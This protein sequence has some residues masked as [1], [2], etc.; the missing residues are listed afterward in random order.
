MSFSGMPIHHDA[1]V[2]TAA[3]DDPAVKYD[4]T[5][6]KA[7]ETTRFDLLK[8]SVT[9]NFKETPTTEAIEPGHANDLASRIN[10]SLDRLS[11]NINYVEED[12]LG[13]LD[14]SD[15]KKHSL[16]ELKNDLKTFLQSK[17]TAKHPKTE[18]KS[19]D[20][21]SLL[22]E[23]SLRFDQNHYPDSVQRTLTFVVSQENSSAGRKKL[24]IVGYYFFMI[25]SKIAPFS[26][27]RSLETSLY[28]N[29]LSGISLNSQQPEFLSIGSK[30]L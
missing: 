4:E 1:V 10:D 30:S 11:I 17:D 8:Q 15:A 12:N 3:L 28:W 6:R 5:V 27:V 9:P 26:D 16:L 19:V 22:D 18:R 23:T 20:L 21:A 7:I 25:R 13:Q 24:K 2:L 29:T 14:L